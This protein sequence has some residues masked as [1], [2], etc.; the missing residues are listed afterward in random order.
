MT[1]KELR[2]SKK[3]TQLKASSICHIPLRTYKRL[4]ND[5]SYSESLKYQNAYKLIDEYVND[6]EDISTYNILLIGAGYVGLS[7]ATILSINNYVDIVDID[8]DKVKRINNRELIY[9]DKDLE[10]YFNN[11]KL[12][13]NAYLPNNNLYKDKDYIIIC[14]PTD[15][16]KNTK[17]LD[18]SNIVNLVK[19]IRDINKKV[20]VVIK[21]TCNIGF[22]DSLNDNNII[23][24]P[25]FLRERSAFYDTLYPSRIII[26]VNKLNKKVKDFAST[27]QHI[28]LNSAKTLFM[29][30]KEAEAVKL[31][32]NSYLAMR[33]AFFNEL[34]SFADKYNINSKN[35]IDGVSQDPRIGDYYNN[36][37]FGYGGYCLPKDTLALS[38]LL[39]ENTLISSISESNN[40]RKDYIVDRVLKLAKYTEDNAN[41]ITVGVFRL[42][43]NFR[44]SSIQDIIKRIKDKGV[45]VIV[46][47]PTL[48]DLD[49]NLTIEIVNNLEKFKKQSNA[50]ITNRYD[51]CL[52]DVIDKVYTRDV[53]NRD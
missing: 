28:T 4:E 13:L 29:T 46:Y 27:L 51:S 11:E 19:D 23:Y 45:K 41:K 8:N 25:E 15:Y 38:S 22:T 20:V 53:F 17:L 48:T 35:I 30:Y 7:I 34:D 36:P 40:R 50:I 5:I 10:H 3:L 32:S 18:T 49:E 52:D 24:C 21:S 43:R 9:V 1:L 12:N 31:F 44:M 26:G 33:V 14:V 6:I 47:E 42:N 39:D 16:D 37:S 2:I